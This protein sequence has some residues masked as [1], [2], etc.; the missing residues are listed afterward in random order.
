MQE[1]LNHIAFSVYASNDSTIWVGTSGGINKSTDGGISWRKFTAQNQTKPISGNWVV[2]IN[3]QILP[4]KRILWAATVN[5]RD[6]NERQGVSFSIDGGETWSTTLLGE[7]AHNIAFRDSIVYVATNSGLFRSVDI[8]K[9]WIRT[10]SI[11]DEYSRQRFASP[12]IYAAAT[13]GDTLWIGGSEGIAYTVDHPASPFGFQWK[14]HRTYEP[15]GSSARTYAFPTPFSPDDEVVRIHYSTGGKTVPVTIRIFDF[16]M[17]PV[18]TLIQN[19]V[20]SGN[21]EH[22]EIWEGRDDL[23]RRVANG[24]YFYRIDVENSESIWGKIHVVQ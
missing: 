14:V 5:T 4:G 19:G 22:D 3:E 10:G 16:A 15:V 21:I 18:R 11:T 8:G 2:A 1:N 23:N 9:T 24:V 12:T 17:F 6:P 7:R 20:R 13:K